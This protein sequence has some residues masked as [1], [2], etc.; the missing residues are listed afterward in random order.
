MG[1]GLRFSVEKDGFEVGMEYAMD[2]AD[3]SQLEKE[4]SRMIGCLKEGGWKQTVRR[5]GGGRG[6]TAPTDWALALGLRAFCFDRDGEKKRVIAWK[7]APAEGS[8]ESREALMWEP[9]GQ[10]EKLPG[11]L[12]KAIA[13]AWESGDR[14][15]KELALTSVRIEVGFADDG[16]RLKALEV[17]SQVVSG[18]LSVASGKTET[19]RGEGS[20]SAKASA[21]ELRAEDF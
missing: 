15:G 17:R 16:G 3:L 12:Q 2:G 13:A 20:A 9:E 18:Q 8:F 1:T 10:M 21:D 14:R 19:A 6:P 7:L 11:P 4:A 5:G